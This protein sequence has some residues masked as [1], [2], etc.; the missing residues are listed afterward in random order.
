MDHRA[1]TTAA[2]SATLDVRNK[3]LWILVLSLGALGACR[4]QDPMIAVHTCLAPP[5]D[6]IRSSGKPADVPC[7]FPRTLTVVAMP[8]QPPLE[9]EL[10]SIGLSQDAAFALLNGD[11]PGNKLCTVEQTAP[12]PGGTKVGWELGC[13]QT[14][15]Q[16][17]RASYVR[18]TVILFALAPTAD[19]RVRLEQL[20][21]SN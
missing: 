19:G 7:T 6:Q 18:G 10:L 2:D 20:R 17:D 11:T 13:M 9:K 15:I 8:A 4:A 3:C 12:P 16:I 21:S 14:E 5:V 1:R